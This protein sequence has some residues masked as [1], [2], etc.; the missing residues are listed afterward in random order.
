[1]HYLLAKEG[2]KYTITFV[3]EGEHNGRIQDDKS[4][5]MYDLYL[6]ML[7]S[8]TMQVLGERLL[9]QK[10]GNGDIAAAN[11][12]PLPK[13]IKYLLEEIKTSK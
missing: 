1:M 8:M 5:Q 6:Q 12:I 10:I 11:M 2:D 7:Y 3:I 9:A 13:N 4:G